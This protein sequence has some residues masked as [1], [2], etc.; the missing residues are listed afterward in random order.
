MHEIIVS[1]YLLIDHSMIKTT[2]GQ[3][4]SGEASEQKDWVTAQSS[5]GEYYV[6]TKPLNVDEQPGLN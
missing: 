3:C 1:L 4:A 5:T 6:Y 2:S